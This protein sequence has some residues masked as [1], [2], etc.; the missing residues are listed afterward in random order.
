M[1][2]V[3]SNHGSGPLSPTES[4]KVLHQELF[5]PPSD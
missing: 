4:D 2:Q 1:Q 5:H 3:Y